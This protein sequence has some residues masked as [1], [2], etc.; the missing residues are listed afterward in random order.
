[1]VIDLIENIFLTGINIRDDNNINF[2][3]LICK[4][5]KKVETRDTNSLKSTV[6]SNREL[7]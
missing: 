2:A 1:M 3:E 4:G 7:Y 5:L 6:S